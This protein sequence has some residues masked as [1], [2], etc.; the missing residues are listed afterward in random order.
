MRTRKGKN[1][2][3]KWLSHLMSLAML[4]VFLSALC[5]ETRAYVMPPGQILGFM[6]KNF[7]SVSTLVVKQ[8][9]KASRSSGEE[10]G[11]L[12]EVKVSLKRPWFYHCE[13][14]VAEEE[15]SNISDA[16]ACGWYNVAKFQCIFLQHSV[17][18]MIGFLSRVGVQ[19]S[20]VSL[21]HIG[22]EIAYL[23]GRRRI[24]ESYLILSRK[25]FLPLLL[26]IGV[27]G[28]PMGPFDLRFNDYRRVDEG[29]Y[30]YR[31][32]CE[33]DHTG[34]E[35]YVAQEAIANISIE[36]STFRPANRQV[37]SPAAQDL[38]PAPNNERV[39]EVIEIFKQRSQ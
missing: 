15:G 33:A 5:S 35:E 31:I 12:V 8:W 17:T 20:E 11:Q 3:W 19:S 4:L 16:R 36:P 2:F 21:T 27:A 1:L 37:N 30:P 9:V 26:H 14:T 32:I 28:S 7:S 22:S 29:F 18:E 34:A 39:K 6:V 24:G 25:T 10:Q 38:A 23:I 13:R